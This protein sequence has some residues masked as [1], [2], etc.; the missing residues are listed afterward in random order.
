MGGED[1]GEG[2]GYIPAKNIASDKETGLGNWSDG[3]IFRAVTMGIDK[4]GEPIAHMMPYLFLTNLYENDIKSIIAY[5]RTLPPIKNNVKQHDLNFPVNLIFRTLPTTPEFKILPDH[6]DKIGSGKYY[7][8]SCMFC[9][10]P[11]GKGDFIKGK[12]FSEGVE[13]PNPKGGII[14]SSNLTP[15]NETGIGNL[16]KEQ[17]I[18]KF[19]SCT[20]PETQ[21]I[22][23]KD[24]EFNT[25]MSWTF[26]CQMNDEDLGSIYEFLRT[27]K[28]VVNKVEKFSPKNK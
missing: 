14:R 12:L 5:I 22:E 8:P 2:A 16:T 18:E 10:S 7:S 25:I 17:F 26:L 4:N 6:K 24:G 28:Q 3:E 1:Y 9:H 15:D 23:V 19:R 20:R 13:F 27:Q 11:M 21:N